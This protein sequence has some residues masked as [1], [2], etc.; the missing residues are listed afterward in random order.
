MAGVLTAIALR[1][2]MPAI[3]LVAVAPSL[4]IQHNATIRTRSRCWSWCWCWRRRWARAWRRIWPL[5]MIPLVH[6]QD[7]VAVL[8]VSVLFDEECAI[9]IE[10]PVV[11]RTPNVVIQG[12]EIIAEP[13]VEC[14]GVLVPIIRLDIVVAGIPWHG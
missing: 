4:V 10:A 7:Q 5:I 3:T 8:N 13:Q 11:A 1:H 2:V 14:V 6:H 9:V 12:I